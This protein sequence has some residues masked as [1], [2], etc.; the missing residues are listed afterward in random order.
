M[1]KSLIRLSVYLALICVPYLTFA[2]SKPK[3]DTSK[4]RS[5][6][7]AKQKSRQQVTV[8]TT[9]VKSKKAS[10]TRR[11]RK[12]KVAPPPQLTS[13]LTVNSMT[14]VFDNYSSNSNFAS[15]SVKTDGKEWSVIYLPYWCRVV[16]SPD[17][18]T[19][20]YDANERYEERFDWFKVVSDKKEVRINIRQSG[21]SVR[22]YSFINHANLQHNV[23]NSSLS[24]YEKYLKIEANITVGGAKGLKCLAVAYICDDYNNGILASPRYKNYAFPSNKNVYTAT[25]LKPTSDSQTFNATLYLPNNAMLLLKKK[26]K[27]RCKLAVY[28][29]K[30][31]SYISSADYTLKFRAKSKKGK[32]ITKKR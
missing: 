20:F 10:V 2:Q 18:F 14:T 21:K 19:I 16:K 27:L 30:T 5:A 17:Y 25:E 28:C 22:A 26:N 12:A 8:Q 31:Q 9:E 3:R 29:V 23:R 1:M 24:Y 11:R 13:Y 7:V 4:D 6:I 15:Y 32:V